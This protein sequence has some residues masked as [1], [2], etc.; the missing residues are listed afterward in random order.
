MLS[1]NNK[2]F[3]LEQLIIQELKRWVVFSKQSSESISSPDLCNLLLFAVSE[4]GDLNSVRELSV[5]FLAKALFVQSTEIEA[6][7]LIHM[8][9][10]RITENTSLAEP[11]ALT[12]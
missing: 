9:V 2:S 8:L 7:P 6:F 11:G 5:S 3:K 12:H 4:R 1:R 10:I